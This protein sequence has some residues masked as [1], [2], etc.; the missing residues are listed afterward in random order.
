VFQANFFGPIDD[1]FLTQR[2]GEIMEMQKCSSAA[3]T[4]PSTHFLPTYSAHFGAAASG[5]GGPGPT[6]SFGSGGVDLHLADAFGAP[7]NHTGV[8]QQHVQG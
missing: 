5:F 8:E 3:G 4:N 7:V 1:G 6:S 2:A